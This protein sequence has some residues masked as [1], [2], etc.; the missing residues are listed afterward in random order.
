MSLIT[1]FDGCCL[2]TAS[3]VN[4]MCNLDTSSI[5]SHWLQF[6]SR[7]TSNCYII[8][9]E[10]PP[11]LT[12]WQTV[13]APLNSSGLQCDAKPEFRLFSQLTSGSIWAQTSTKQFWHTMWFHTWSN[14]LKPSILYNLPRPLTILFNTSCCTSNACEFCNYVGYSTLPPT[15]LHPPDWPSMPPP[16]IWDIAMDGWMD[17]LFRRYIQFI[18][19]SW[20]KSLYFTFI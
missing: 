12:L 18:K 8:Q 4:E 15:D 10:C 2:V 17:I 19:S 1:S 9:D 5:I 13:H 7:N 11:E 14:W 20:S 3:E 6:L 16:I